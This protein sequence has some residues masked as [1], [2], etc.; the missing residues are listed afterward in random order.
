MKFWAEC[1]SLKASVLAGLG[2]S[3]GAGAGRNKNW[4]IQETF[5]PTSLTLVCFKVKVVTF[6][7]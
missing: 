2:G 7:F 4:R 3:G 5:F 1:G 6:T